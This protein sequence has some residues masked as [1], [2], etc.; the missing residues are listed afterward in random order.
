MKK[1]IETWFTR[2]WLFTLAVIGV[3]CNEAIGPESKSEIKE[4]LSARYNAEMV[5]ATQDALDITGAGMVS[6]GVTSGRV[7]GGNDPEDEEEIED[8]LC[9]ATVTKSVTMVNT[10]PDS[11]LVTGIITIDFGDGTQCGDSSHRRSGS[12][13]TEF[14]ISASKKSHEVYHSTETVTLHNFT[15][16]AKSVSGKFISTAAPG[17]LQWLKV[18][19]AEVTYADSV[20]T[21]IAWSGELTV[22][23]DNA[24]TRS[25]NDDIK[26]VSGSITGTTSQG[27]F[28]S[29]ITNDLIIKRECYRGRNIPVSGTIVVTSDETITTL[30]FGDGTCDKLYTSTAAG[31]TTELHF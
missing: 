17:G 26:T 3:S 2:S 8:R 14:V 31:E 19:N 5:M 6:Q 20:E 18:Q 11:L 4:E 1:Q 15:Q 29:E 9:G 28:S 30:D 27:S 21:T 13:T 23:H 7:A 22:T 12:I 25:H 24:G 16:G 10:H